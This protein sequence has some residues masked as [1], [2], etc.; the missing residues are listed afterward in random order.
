MGEK[1][2]VMEK[3][4]WPGKKRTKAARRARTDSDG[5]GARP[6]AKAAPPTEKKVEKGGEAEES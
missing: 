2:A 1:G 5:K 4:T 6:D 3:P